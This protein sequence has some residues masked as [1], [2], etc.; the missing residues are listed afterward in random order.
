M[1]KPY[2]DKPCNHCSLGTYEVPLSGQEWHVTCNEC[3]TVMF[4][5]EPQPYQAEFHED[6]S[7][8][9]AF[10]GGYGSG[11]TTTSVAEVIDHV[12]ST[13][14]GQTLMGAATLPQLEQTSQ[15]EF[16][17]M[18]PDEYIV[19][20]N[21]QK[22]FVDVINGHRI[23]FR[24]LDDEGKARS[25]NLTCFH[26]EEA[27]E[28]DYAYYVQLTTR[29]RNRATDKH[30]GIL[31]SNPDM[32]WV[33]NEILLKASKIYNDE[34]GYDK[35]QKEEDINPNISVHIAPTHLNKYL[36]EDYR[37]TTAQGKEDWWIK[38]YLDGSFENK[39]GLVYPHYEENIVDAFPIPSHW[40]RKIG[41]D[42]GINN[43]TA[44]IFM[45]TDPETGI[46]YIYDEHEEAQQPV[47]YH[48][49]KLNE[50]L[51]T[52]AYNVIE[53]MVGD[54]SGQQKGAD[55]SS[56]FD[57]YA[58]YGIYWDAGTKKLMDSI[59]K[60][61]G[62]FKLGKLKIFNTCTTF[63]KEVSE[64]R[65]PDRSLDNDTKT[66]DYYERP[67][68]KNDHLLD[69]CRYVV[70]EM[71][72]NP[73]AMINKSYNAMHVILNRNNISTSL[74]HALQE[75]DTTTYARSRDGWMSY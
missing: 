22:N 34:I 71:P 33:K 59:A 24:P 48:A 57:H 25:L 54:S 8:F 6:E 53:Y 46:T 49:E 52:L 20:H 3:S 4:C 47:H 16:F 60:M 9:K 17:E 7:K 44:F 21:Q 50:R 36:P 56:L 40:K 10:F 15:K 38:R 30:K 28:V 68:A 66:D 31:S 45:A 37:E 69:A 62:Y 42:F 72:D 55:M 29:L 27:S 65:Y 18:F 63:I 35:L 51:D 26:I 39:E 74:P 5:Y 2:V 70:H 13:P 11:K 12:L 43:P 58:E 14:N 41:G 1:Q 32:G 23:L 61:Y 19:R 67:I 64:Y 73:D 75:E